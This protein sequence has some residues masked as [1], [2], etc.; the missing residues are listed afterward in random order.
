MLERVFVTGNASADHLVG[1]PG[2]NLERLSVESCA[3]LSIG[4]GLEEGLR[5]PANN[6][7]MCSMTR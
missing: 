2:D 6:L 7:Q 4:D 3:K 1:D 5:E